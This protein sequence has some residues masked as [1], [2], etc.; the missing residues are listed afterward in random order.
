MVT[1][2]VDDNLP[3]AALYFL[4]HC[5]RFVNEEWQ[6]ATREDLPDQGFERTFRASCIT[7]LDSWG[8]SPEREM[9]LGYELSTASGV[10]HEVDIVAKHAEVTAIV[11]LKN[12]QGPPAKN[13]VVI[14]FAKILDYLAF[15]P[16]LLLKEMCP[17]FLSTAS[18]EASGLAACLGLGIHPVGPGLRPVPILVDSAKRIDVELQRGVVVSQE[19]H[20]RFEDFCAELNRIWLSLMDSWLTS[21]CGYRSDDTIV[22]KAAGGLDT[23][24]LGYS[25]RQLNSDCTWLLAEVRKA[26]A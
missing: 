15:N 25:L 22:L 9:R 4:K 3:E 1:I 17:I 2:R 5:Y 10:L 23:L 13:D 24:A 12:R 7:G 14:L 16:V 18:F 8:I 21:R 26:M 11:E 19:M 20:E 6:H